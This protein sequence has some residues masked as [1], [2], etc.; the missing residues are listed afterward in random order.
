M[1]IQVRIELGCINGV[2]NDA[3]YCALFGLGA[4]DK[5]ENETKPI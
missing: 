5:N 2:V 4:W 1:R 3:T